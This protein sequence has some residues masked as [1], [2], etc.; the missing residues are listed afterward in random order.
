MLTMSQVNHIKDLSN[1]GYRISEISKETDTD[2]KTIRKYLSQEDFS[3]VPPVTVENHPFSTRSSLS[4][5]SG[6]RTTG[7]TGASSTIPPKGFTSGWWKN[8]DIQAAT[9]SCSAI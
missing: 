2:P 9:A 1:C 8:R 4:S 5:G 3:P 6:S 7:N